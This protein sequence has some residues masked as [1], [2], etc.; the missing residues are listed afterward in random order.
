MAVV[1]SAVAAMAGITVAE[2]WV[3]VAAM[4]VIMAAAAKRAKA[5]GRPLLCRLLSGCLYHWPNLLLLIQLLSH[6]DIAV[7]LLDIRGIA[8]K[9]V[10]SQI[11]G[12]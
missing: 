8:S 2:G 9:S 10:D 5:H 12:N 11:R 4:V 7:A 6:T 1:D 3:A